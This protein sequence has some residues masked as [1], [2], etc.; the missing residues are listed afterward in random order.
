M[1]RVWLV[2][3]DTERRM[4]SCVWTHGEA[5][6][7]RCAGGTTILAATLVASMPG[8]DIPPSEIV[9]RP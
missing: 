9:K 5:G 8:G 1:V 2:T 7:P 3:A 4:A 6:R